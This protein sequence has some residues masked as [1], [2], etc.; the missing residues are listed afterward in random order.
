VRQR[1]TEIKAGELSRED[2]EY[3]ATFVKSLFTLE[4]TRY[5]TLAEEIESP[6]TDE[7]L[8]NI[9]D[10]ESH[11][12]WYFGLR[13]YDKFVIE[14]GRLPGSLDSTQTEDASKLEELGSALLTAAGLSQKLRPE[15]ATELT[16]YQDC[17]LHV[18]SAYLG[19]VAAQEAVKLLTK[20]YT[21]FNN[22]FIWNGIV[23]HGAT[24]EL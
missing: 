19:G 12:Q 2:E 20:Q 8:C 5:R 14:T 11:L 6:N 22:T 16:R 9:D 15:V 18:T 1:L 17:E 4:V 7:L 10:D 3:V 23:S 21:P 13:A 24:I